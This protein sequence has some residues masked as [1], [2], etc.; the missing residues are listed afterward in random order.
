MTSDE[1]AQILEAAKDFVKAGLAANHQKNT[2]KAAKIKDY[3]INPFLV[4]YLA[5]FAFGDSSPENIAKALIYPRVLGTS[6]TTTFG[7]QLQSFC[8]QVLNNISSVQGSM[9]DGIDIEFTDQKDGRQKYCQVKSGPNTI[10]K[11]DI[12]TIEDH[13][14][15]AT[16]VATQNHRTVGSTDFVVGVFY[17]T[18]DELSSHYKKI[19]EDNYPVYVGKDFWHR[20]TGDENFYDDLIKAFSTAAAEINSADLFQDS[21]QQLATEIEKSSIQ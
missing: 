5:R 16:G 8:S 17:G 4:N 7:T 13:F 18:E 11:S 9:T 10:N 12:K 14:K 6:I 15:K 21:I 20:L 2:K 1:K 19:K 3:K